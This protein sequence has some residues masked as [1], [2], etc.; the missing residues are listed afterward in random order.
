MSNNTGNI[1]FF[2]PSG[3]SSGG[4]S[5]GA[6][7][8]PGPSNPVDEFSIL[9]AQDYTEMNVQTFE[10]L[11][12]WTDT[13]DTGTFIYGSPQ[14]IFQNLTLSTLDLTL[15][16]FVA[17]T[18]GYYGYTVTWTA[19]NGTN[20]DNVVALAINGLISAPAYPLFTGICLLNT[21]DVVTVVTYGFSQTYTIPYIASGY[22]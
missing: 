1:R 14:T 10:A 16:Q 8:P 15:G 9:L 17:G 6:T 3:G 18:R 11:P 12:N 19:V 2:G 20:S 21:G 22:V 7:G 13:L 4:G 5:T